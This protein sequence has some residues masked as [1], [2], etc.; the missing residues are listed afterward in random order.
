MWKNLDLW[1]ARWVEDYENTALTSPWSDSKYKFRD[2]NSW[3]FWQISADN[4]GLG[5]MFGS[6]DGDADM[7]LNWFNGTLTE[8]Y[9]YANISYEP[10]VV[11]LEEWARE[12]DGFLRSIGYI[13]SLPPHLANKLISVD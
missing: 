3:K 12:A 8:L 2:W 7:D 6:I 5:K 9:K 13:G 1:A 11:S 4:N 10:E